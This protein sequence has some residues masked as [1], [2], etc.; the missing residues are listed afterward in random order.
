MR[1]F[2][3]GA[4]GFAGS[5][6]A[7]L[8]LARGHEVF[9][10]VQPDVSQE[11]LAEAL[12]GP[13]AARLHVIQGDLLDRH[14]PAV[15]RESRPDAVYHL[16]ALSSVRQSLDDPAASFRVN[17]LG[18]QALLEAVLLAGLWPRVLY[19]GSGEAYGE[20]ARL[21]RPVREEDPLLPVTP[22]GT[23]KAAAEQV[24]SRYARE[25]GLHVV[26]VR[27]F[28]HTGP[29]H[30]PQFVFPDLARQLAEIE[31]RARAPRLEVGNLEVRRDVTDVRDMVAAYALAL[32][33][34]ERGAVYNVCSG[35][36]W[37]LREVLD[38]LI[39]LSAAD[40]EV[41]VQPERLRPQD[42]EVLAGD[43]A[44]FRE[45]TGWTPAI[46]LERTLRDLL[47]YWRARQAA[48]RSAR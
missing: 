10:L 32:A 39:A 2:V 43:P 21:P 41:V 29:R 17:V 18:T 24:A 13:H 28:P 44:A 1:C 20:S 45:R 7:E 15:V 40:V 19:V 12:A 25:R 14:L 46:P 36:V 42:L 30:S 6:L 38:L 37:A 27:P 5:H 22:Y 31:A 34:G 26:R 33:G 4:A 23:S 48:E 3:T 47:D 9:G 16:A 11:N 35:R 8:L